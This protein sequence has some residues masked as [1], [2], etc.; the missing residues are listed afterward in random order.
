MGACRDYASKTVW[1]F[2][3][4]LRPGKGPAAAGFYT[5]GKMVMGV[6]STLVGEAVNDFFYPGITEAAHNGENLPRHIVRATGALFVIGLV[7]FGLLVLSGPTLFDFVFSSD[8]AKA[9]EKAR[10]LS[11]WLLTAFINRPSVATIPVLSLQRGFLVYE[12]ASVI[13]RASAIVLGVSL[14]QSD[15][16]AIALFSVVGVVLNLFLIAWVLRMAYS[17]ERTKM[18]GRT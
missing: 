15:L 14:F 6:P 11:L 8:W 10:W 18:G 4:T 13:A 9:G 5:L 2:Y 17:L 1:C 7:P 16:V 12:I 3:I